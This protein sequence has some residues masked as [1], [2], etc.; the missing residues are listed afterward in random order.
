MAGTVKVL[1]SDLINFADFADFA[2]LG[3]DACMRARSRTHA[4]ART[5][6]HLRLRIMRMHDSPWRSGK[7]GKVCQVPETTKQIAAKF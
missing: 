7:V 6:P 4:H 1:R 5:H 3:M 2:V